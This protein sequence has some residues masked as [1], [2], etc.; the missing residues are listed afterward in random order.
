MYNGISVSQYI[1]IFTLDPESG[2]NKSEIVKF[3]IGIKSN[4][5]MWSLEMSKSFASFHADNNI[6]TILCCSTL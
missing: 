6:L 1:D 2:K 4:M 3:F 5:K